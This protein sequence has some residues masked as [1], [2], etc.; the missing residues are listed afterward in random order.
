MKRASACFVFSVLV[1]LLATASVVQAGGFALYEWGNRALGMGTANYATGNDASVI[2][3][4]PAEMSKLEGTNVYGGVTAVSPSS[5]VY[6]DGVESHTQNQVFGVPHGYATHQVNDDWTLGVGVYTRFGLGT[7]YASNWPG[8]T[9]IQDA[10]LE[11]FSLNP[12]VS[13]K[14]NDSLSVGGGLEIIKGYFTTHQEMTTP[15]GGIL[16]T[17]VDGVSFAFNL[18]LLYDIND[19]FS[20]GLTYRS[21]MH[22]EGEGTVSVTGSP[23]PVLNSSGDATM[24]ADFPASYTVGLGFTPT[25]KLTFEFDIVYTQW[26]QFDRIEYCFTNSPLPNKMVDFNYKSTWRFQ[27]GTEY[28]FTDAFAM[29]AGYVYDQTPIRGDYASP[30]LPAN[31]RQM[32]TL[33]AGYKWSD[34]T[35]DVA[36]MY[37]ITKERKG[38]SMTDSGGTTYKVDFKNGST[39]GLGSSIGYHF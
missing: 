8:Q 28:R 39:W 21:S 1:C 4:N 23:I 14:V 12:V 29:R 6:V 10:L 2:A 30:M 17:D 26:E 36:G 37:I 19:M 18:G 7:D 13:Y 34:W 5:D 25:D 3:Y 9:L 22:F 35:L 11:T 20:V 32:F 24:I 38:M 27:L 31:D 16:M 33:G 15:G